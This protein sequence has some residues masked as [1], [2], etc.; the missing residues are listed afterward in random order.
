MAIVQDSSVPK[1]G[2]RKS[3]AG[4]Q[5]WRRYRKNKLAVFGLGFIGLLLL[6]SIFAP[7]L[8]PHNPFQSIKN[9]A[10][11][12]DIM[13]KPDSTYWLGTD[14]LGRDILSR[15]LYAGRVSL[16]VGIVSV[17]ISTVLG[18]LLGAVAGYYGKWADSII[19]RVV[20]VVYCFPVMFLIITVSTLL[21]PSI[22]NVMI[23]IGLVSWTSTARLVRGEILRVRELEYVQASKAL[24]VS[25]FSIILQHILPNIMAP[26][27]VQATLMT[28]DAILTEAALSFLGVGVQQP[29]PSWGN[30]L[31]EAMSI[32]VL[33]F[34]YWIWLYPGL[35]ILLTVL[36]INFIG[37]GLRDALDPK[38]KGRK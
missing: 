33:R 34:K 12:L 7:W 30:M 6:V 26:I 37:D 2:K 3:G 20:D 35:A 32:L 5:T 8:A 18:I 24:G 14:S 11:G 31:N 22:Y 4:S 1:L 19:M 17:T 16:S 13:A 23:I 29:T 25:D 27:L 21:K 9:A 36:S 38:L 10:G 28:A 15:L